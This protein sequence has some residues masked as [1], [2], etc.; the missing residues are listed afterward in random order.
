MKNKITPFKLLQNYLLYAAPFVVLV[1]VWSSLREP[2]AQPPPNLLTTAVWELGSWNLMLWFGCLL[3]FLGCLLFASSAREKTLKRIANV[4]DQDER[5]E[6]IS[7]KASRRSYIST[8][9]LLIFLLFISVFSLEIKRVPSEQAMDGKTGVLN[10]GFNFD[11]F[12]RTQAPTEIAGEQQY[13]AAKDIPL[14][15]SGII[16]LILIWQVA[17][18]AWSARRELEPDRA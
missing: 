14:S 5:E 13:F 6:L 16:L 15:K 9:S 10:I 17:T 2:N 4:R 11:F 12:D 8:L 1:M 3:V 7:G 18:F